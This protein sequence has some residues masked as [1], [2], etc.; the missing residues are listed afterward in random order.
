MSEKFEKLNLRLFDGAAAGG[1]AE[2]GG[3]EASGVTG[4]EV[5][6]PVHPKAKKPDNVVYGKQ[7]PMQDAQ[8]ATV[9]TEAA[10]EET[11]ESLIKGKYKADFDERVQGIVRKR[12]GED[13]GKDELIGKLAPLVSLVGERYGIDANDL[14]S[15]DVDALTEKVMSDH[16]KYEAL[17]EKFGVSVDTAREIDGFQRRAESAERSRDE[18][19][20]DLKNREHFQ[21]VT[22]QAAELKSLY[23]DFDLM[24]EMQNPQFARLIGPQVNMPVKQVYQMI[25][26]DELIQ[27]AMNQAAQQ[28]AQSV[29]MAVQAGKNRPSENG[30][31]Q[32]VEVRDDP[33][34]WSKQDRVNVRERV[35]RG[36]KI[37]L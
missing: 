18:M 17:A 28:S 27:G 36:E 32:A 14:K 23:P 3:G 7:P 25:H 8:P 24:T 31:P 12:I 1:A 20:A 29:S 15:L 19:I 21:R 22:A 13:K 30:S 10:P 9:Q 2:A 5:A 34:L 11:F 33:R 35:R 6:A 26:H 16:P 37:Y 4:Q